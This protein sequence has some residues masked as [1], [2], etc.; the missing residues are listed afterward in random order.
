[1][2]DKYT[3]EG[4]KR[5]TLR[6]EKNLFEKIEEIAVKS[7]RSIGRQIEYMLSKLV[8]TDDDIYNEMMGPEAFKEPEPE[9]PQQKKKRA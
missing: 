9:I 4:D 2:N 3:R 1:M 8:E 7:K 6:I 5:F